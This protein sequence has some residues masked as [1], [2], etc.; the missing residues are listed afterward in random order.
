MI[1]VTA[2]PAPQAAMSPSPAAPGPAPATAR[3]DAFQAGTHQQPGGMG[4]A[5]NNAI[6]GF[7]T[8]AQQM[9]A[10]M[11]DIAAGPPDGG[12]SGGGLSGARSPAVQELS[13]TASLRPGGGTPAPNPMAL[14]V[15]SFNFAIEASLVSRAATQ[16]TGSVSTL[17]KGQ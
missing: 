9:Q 8:R 15:D 7:S 17:M 14:M 6:D 1:P 3:L 4:Q 10:S 11:R 12:L 2:L 13:P 16:F 5:F